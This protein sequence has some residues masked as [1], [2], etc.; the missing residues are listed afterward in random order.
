MS[1][2]QAQKFH[3]GNAS[4]PTSSLRASSL[5]RSDSGAGKGRRACNYVSVI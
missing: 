1:E 5:G 2:E 3:S 4:L